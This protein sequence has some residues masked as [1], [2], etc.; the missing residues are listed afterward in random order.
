MVSKTGDLK[1]GTAEYS[2]GY[3]W[4]VGLAKGLVGRPMV[5]GL[6]VVVLMGKF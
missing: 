2:A 5:G 4:P 1:R 6:K 3:F